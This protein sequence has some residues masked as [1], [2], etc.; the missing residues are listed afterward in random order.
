[1]VELCSA[2]ADPHSWAA[3]GV[4]AVREVV[5]GVD[6]A[7]WFHLFELDQTFLAAERLAAVL[8]LQRVAR[9][10]A[11][12]AADAAGDHRQLAEPVV[13]EEAGVAAQPLRVEFALRTTKEWT[14]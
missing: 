7:F 3:D 1:M 11:D 12:G 8:R 4:L 2:C 13:V 6:V 14:E 10:E 5:H 9:I